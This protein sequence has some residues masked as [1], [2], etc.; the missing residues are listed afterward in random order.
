VTKN[1]GSAVR[2]INRPKQPNETKQAAFLMFQQGRTIAEVM[3]CAGRAQSTVVEYLSEF[4]ETCR[5]AKIDAWVAPAA[6]KRVV[7]AAADAETPRLKP[8]FERLG[9]EVPYEEIRL[10]LTHLRTRSDA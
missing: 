5:P 7:A 10:V 4:I 3:A 1:Q 2:A 9:G 8:L 6:Y